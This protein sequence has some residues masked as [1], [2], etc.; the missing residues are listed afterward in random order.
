MAF[1]VASYAQHILVIVV[2]VSVTVFAI[3]LTPLKH[4]NIIEPKIDDIASEVFY[5]QYVGNE[6][7]YIFIDVRGNSSYDR[8]HAKG[9]INMPLHT[10][11]DERLHLPKNDTNKEIVLICSGGVASGVGYHYLEHHGFRNIKRIQGGIQAWQLSG[12]PVETRI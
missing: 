5:E 3:Y 1:R 8:I 7:N 12:L 10:L 6:D 2:T 9:S 11:Y 4:F